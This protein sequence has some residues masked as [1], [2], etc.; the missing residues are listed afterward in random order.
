MHYSCI[1]ICKKERLGLIVKSLGKRESFE[2]HAIIMILENGR[3]SALGCHS[4][5][6]VCVND[7]CNQFWKK[8]PSTLIWHLSYMLGYKIAIYYMLLPSN[9]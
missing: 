8:F 6:A 5:M 4:F 2:Q 9:K 1:P 7:L 3:N